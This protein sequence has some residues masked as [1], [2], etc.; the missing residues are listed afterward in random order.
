MPNLIHPFQLRVEQ[1]HRKPFHTPFADFQTHET[2]NRSCPNWKDRRHSSFQFTVSCNSSDRAPRCS[3]KTFAIP[4]KEA[5]SNIRCSGAGG[6]FGSL[7]EISDT[8]GY[9]SCAGIVR[10]NWSVPQALT[11]RR[12]G[13]FDPLIFADSLCI[14]RQALRMIDT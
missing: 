8:D 14:F 11:G 7:Y 12:L 6:R 13:V 1:S 10:G 9:R 4:C 5:F 3:L 2:I